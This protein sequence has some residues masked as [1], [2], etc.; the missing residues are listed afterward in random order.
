MLQCVENVEDVFP[1]TIIEGVLLFS[2]NIER[3][4]SSPIDEGVAL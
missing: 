3:I 2:E 1:A 4:I